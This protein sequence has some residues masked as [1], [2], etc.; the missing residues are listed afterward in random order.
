MSTNFLWYPGTTNNGLLTT[1]VTLMST[2]MNSLANAGTA[3]SSVGGTSGKFINGNTAQGM[4]GDMFLTLGTIG[5][6]LSAGASLSGWFLTSYNGSSFENTV[7]GSSMSRPPDFYIPLPATTITSGWIYK[8]AGPVMIPA[9]EF[10]V[11][12][13]NNSG[14]TFASSGQTLILAPYAMQY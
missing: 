11:Y 9:L 7:S 10:Y 12:V 3:K 4:I 14:Q 2:E 6:A 1:A 5:T 8:A 13:Q